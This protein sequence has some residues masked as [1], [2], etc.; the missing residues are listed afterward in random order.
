MNLMKRGYK[1]KCLTDSKAAAEYMDQNV[2]DTTVGFRGSVTLDEM[3]LLPMLQKHNTVYWHNDPKQTEEFGSKGGRDM[4][5][6]TEI[7]LMFMTVRC[8]LLFLY[9]HKFFSCLRVLLFHDRFGIRML[10]GVHPSILSWYKQES[11]PGL[12]P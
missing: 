8:F 2:D 4:A 10:H 7:F 12:L 3:Q 6:D 11:S 5:I 1:V 9:R